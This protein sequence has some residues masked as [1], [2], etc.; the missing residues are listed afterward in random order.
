MDKTVLTAGVVAVIVVLAVTLL[1]DP[2][3]LTKRP[4]PVEEP[5]PVTTE[6]GEET[7]EEAGEEEGTEGEQEGE[8]EETEPSPEQ[9]EIE[10][11]ND[12]YGYMPEEITGDCTLY[13]HVVEDHYECFGTAGN[14]STM[15]TNEYK[16]AESDKYFCKPTKYGCKLY[17]KVD[18]LI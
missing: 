18:F 5:E 11:T 4:S 2:F 1:L 9:E 10:Y 7:E 3:G 13:K 8:E 14:F 6:S 17:Q 15:V 12:T 16:T